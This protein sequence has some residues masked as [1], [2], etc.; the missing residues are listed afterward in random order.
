MLIV[1]FYWKVIVHHEFVPRGETVNK[2]FYLKVMKHLREAVRR[3]RPEAWTKKT[4]ML[5]HDNAPAHALLLILEFL[6]KQE[7]IVMPQP[8]LSPD[9][10]PADFFVFPKLKSTLKGCQFQMVEEIKEN[11]PRALNTHSLKP[12]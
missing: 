12:T 3:K 7:M 11:S 8:P 2:E 6:A 10:A 9:L 5:C 1:F 4:W